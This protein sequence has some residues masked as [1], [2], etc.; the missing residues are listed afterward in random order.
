V[1]FVDRHDELRRLDQALRQPGAFA[2]IWGRR[3][4]GKSRLL[5]EWSRRRGGLYTVADQSASAIQ[6][7]Y[8]AAAV[9][10][11]FPGFADVE[12]PDW[13][14]LLERLSTGAADADWPGPFIIDELPYLIAA[15]RSVVAVLQ[16]WL[17]R[18]ERRPC[19]VVS[20]SSRHMMHGAALSADAPLFGRAVEAFAVRPLR[21]GYLGDLF[22][23]MRARH[24][25]SLYAL[26]GG[27][28]RYWELARP[29]GDD[30]ATAIDTL[31]LDPAGPLHDEPDRLLLSEMP[32]ATAL[33]PILDVIGAGGHRMSE[34]AGRLGRP[35]A[36]LSRPL[37]TLAEMDFVRREI[38]FGSNPAS[39][40]R[41]LYRI[42]DPFLRLWF[43]VVAPHRAVLA[44]AP[45]DTRLAYWHRYRTGLEAYAWEELCRMAVPMLHLD[46]SPLAPLGPWEPA[47]RY[48]RGNAPEFDIV[49]RS[50]DG[51]R[52]LVGEAKWSARER[53]VARAGRPIG[54]DAIPGSNHREVVSAAF[55][56][57]AS[58]KMD[59]ATGVH[60]VDAR[61]IMSVLR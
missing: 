13:R 4:V 36:S 22:G 55:V 12:Y 16:N 42:D 19:L 50:V 25:V 53:E 48:W 15:D 11:R 20:G 61:T 35:A 30:L 6:R 46:D 41:S 49:A 39:G 33:R 52:L 37:A 18:P 27:L 23:G 29:Y 58:S 40:K 2:V 60:L 47:Q 17:D 31:V 44:E 21:P 3:R 54:I 8:L 59:S 32:P 51:Q 45:R 57:A 10:Q 7:G 24:L 38:P 14:S 26:W 34:I 9:A 28:P 5:I 56:P 43:R 1:E